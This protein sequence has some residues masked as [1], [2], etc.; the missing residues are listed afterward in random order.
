MQQVQSVSRHEVSNF[1]TVGQLLTIDLFVIDSII[2]ASP[3]DTTTRIRY[4]RA[5]STQQ[6]TYTAA[7]TQTQTDTA[8]AKTEETVEEPITVQSKKNGV[9]WLCP[10]VR[11]ALQVFFIIFLV[12]LIA[13][14]KKYLF[15]RC[16]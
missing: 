10:H 15:L 5:T 16:K 13:I 1:E 14:L 2:E 6:S 11:T 9:A 8:A 3:R 7:E 12:V 4:I